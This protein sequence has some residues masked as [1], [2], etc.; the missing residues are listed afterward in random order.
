MSWPLTIGKRRELLAGWL[1]EMYSRSCQEDARH[2]SL[3]NRAESQHYQKQARIIGN[4]LARLT[5][6]EH[7]ITR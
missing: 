6:L 2:K 7:P 4:L 5:Q 3:G 1:W